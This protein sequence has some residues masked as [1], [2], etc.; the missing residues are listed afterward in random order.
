MRMKD[1]HQVTFALLCLYKFCEALVST[2]IKYIFHEQVYLECAS[3]AFKAQLCSGH[4]S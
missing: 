3:S 2:H 1:G 4:F